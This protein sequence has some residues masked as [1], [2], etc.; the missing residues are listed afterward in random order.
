MGGGGGE[1]EGGTC[2]PLTIYVSLYRFSKPECP[3]GNWGGIYLYVVATTGGYMVSA[4]RSVQ[5]GC[6]ALVFGPKPYETFG[7]F[8]SAIFGGSRRG[9]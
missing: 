3:S 5:P 2:K 6:S 8:K 7:T 9:Y 4:Y 1:A